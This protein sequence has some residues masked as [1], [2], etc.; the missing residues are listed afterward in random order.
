VQDKEGKKCSENYEG[1]RSPQTRRWRCAWVAPNRATAVI[2]ARTIKVSAERMRKVA[3]HRQ[4]TG[5]LD[6]SV[7]WYQRSYQPRF[8]H[9][10][11]CASASAYNVAS[12]KTIRSAWRSER[13]AHFGC[14]TYLLTTRVIHELNLNGLGADDRKSCFELCE[15]AE[16]LCE[17]I[18]DLW[19][20]RT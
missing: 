10:R 14:D 11:S 7:T 17:F 2:H 18:V 13:R 16:R 6:V 20:A 12:V 1:S 8:N 4:E 5:P 15:H 3:R 9:R 19:D